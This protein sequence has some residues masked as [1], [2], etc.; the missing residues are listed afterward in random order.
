MSANPET[1]NPETVKPMSVTAA[2]QTTTARTAE[3]SVLARTG[4]IAIATGLLMC[5]LIAGIGVIA[6]YWL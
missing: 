4:N 5:P 3:K 2:R 6:D 1:A